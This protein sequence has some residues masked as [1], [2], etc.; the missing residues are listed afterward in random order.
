MHESGVEIVMDDDGM[1]TSLPVDKML[2]VT[3]SRLT[4]KISTSDEI[5]ECLRRAK[6]ARNFI[7]HEGASV[8]HISVVRERHIL[9]HVRRLR[10]AVLDLAEG[11]NIVSQ[12]GFHFEEPRQSLPQDLIDAYSQM[13]DGWVF[14][15]FGALLDEET[16]DP[17]ATKL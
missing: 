6:E 17:A 16:V 4:G 12:W 9:G 10:S 2:A 8:G 15:H 5:M 14:G 11:D 7:A 3:L 13:I 1:I